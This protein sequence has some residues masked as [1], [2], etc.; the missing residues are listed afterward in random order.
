MAGVEVR[1]L[2]D[3][4]Q[5][6]E[7]TAH[8]LA[9]FFSAATKTLE[10]AVYD[11]KLPKELGDIVC[12]ALDDAQKRGV[13][14]RLAYNLD[15]AKAVPVPPPPSTNP[16]ALEADPFPTAA[17][18]GVPD[19]MH[20]KYVVRDG[21]SVWTG[22]VNWTADS[23]TREE[24]VAIAIDSPGLASRYL[25]DFEQLWT[26]RDV[27][28]TGKVDTAPIDGMRAWFCPGRGE[29]LAHRIAKAIGSAKRRVRIAS[30]VISSAPILATLAQ[31]ASDRKVDL[32]GV[33][34]ATQVAEVFAQWRENGNVEWKAPLL[35]TTLTRAP[36]SGKVSTPYTPDSVHDY[37]HAK[38]TVA[39]DTVFVGS[40]NLSH[41]G[42]M[43]AENVVELQDPA[44]AERLADF[45]DQIRARYPAVQVDSDSSPV[46]GIPADTAHIPPPHPDS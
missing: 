31:V 11:L 16:D 13:A 1:T 38:V 45:I 41:S 35:R 9:E 15:H 21:A 14:V 12:G 19:L 42:E 7:D 40:F 17:I 8:A 20:H 10:I 25:A 43:N 23:W 44:I 39:D 37:M 30:P 24:N 22:S 2:T 33:V 6:A 32:A 36:F 26:T 18:P 27:A 5:P 46:R 3:G 34:D 28:H 29:K 4:G